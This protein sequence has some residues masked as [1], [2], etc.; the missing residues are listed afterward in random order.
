LDG[1]VNLV[2]NEK[3]I[4][5]RRRKFM[6][7]CSIGLAGVAAGSASSMKLA[8]AEEGAEKNVDPQA[9]A[10]A[11]YEH[12]I[13]GKRTCCEAILMAGCEALGIRSDLVPDIGL[14]LA[15]G[16]G[17][18]GCT[19]GVVTGSAMVVSL[20]VA[21]KEKEYPKKKTQSLQAAGRIHQAFKR[22]VGQTQC[23]S[24]CGLDLTTAKG[25]ERLKTEVKA[26]TCARYVR[27]GARLLAEELRDM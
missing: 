23:R 1:L 16:I 27:V 21:A 6:N 22:E 3:G 19:C 25:R 17:L 18:Q 20:A 5:M 10:K 4:E 7:T 13:P 9:L 12:F 24:L 8:G 26:K 14:G 2:C 11:A 15:G